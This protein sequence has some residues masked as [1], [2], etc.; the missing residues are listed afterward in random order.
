MSLSRKPLAP[1]R[2]ASKTYSSRS[3]V[4][5]TMTFVSSHFGSARIRRV[6]SRPSICGIR[7][8]MSTTSGR[9]DVGHGDRLDPVG[10]LADDL[11]VVGGLD[12]DAEAR[13]HERL[14]VRDQDSDGHWAPPFGD[15]G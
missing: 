9:V 7:M 11:E 12:E 13:A 6:A 8:S 2:S 1:E 5:S 10:G 4:V 14:V 3:N 15:S